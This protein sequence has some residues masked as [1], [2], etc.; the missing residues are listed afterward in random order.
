MVSITA[1][2]QWDISQFCADCLSIGQAIPDDL[3][4]RFQLGFVGEILANHQS[5]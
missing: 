2:A 4:K 1:I 5:G 3:S